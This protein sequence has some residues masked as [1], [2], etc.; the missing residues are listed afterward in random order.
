MTFTVLRSAP[1]IQAVSV[2]YS[3]AD[4]TATASGDYTATSGRLT[5]A[6]GE[7]RKTIQVAIVGD[8]TF[9]TDERFT[10]LLSNPVNATI[11]D[12]SGTGTIQ[13][14]DPRPPD[15]VFGNGVRAALPGVIAEP[16]FAFDAQASGASATGRFQSSALTSRVEVDVKCLMVAG[17]RAAI[18]GV[19]QEGSSSGAGS[20]FVVW[21]ED[22]GPGGG[23]G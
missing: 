11:A 23:T 19:V 5:F 17:K 12:G 1:A 21:I 16:A 18:G 14:D 4:A 20:Q 13:N 10:V 15:R 9:E 2:S 6:R 8:T 22:G 3:T 7:T